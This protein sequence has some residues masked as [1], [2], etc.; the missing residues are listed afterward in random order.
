MCRVKVDL[1][2]KLSQFT[3]RNDTTPLF[4][5]LKR[6]LL[7]LKSFEQDGLV[8]FNDQGFE[9]T[10]TGRYFMRPIAAIFDR[11]SNPMFDRHILPFS[12]KL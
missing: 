8:S 9:I 12:R 11:Y 4:E 3:V 10:E 5:Y 1:S 2:T 6:E 7:E